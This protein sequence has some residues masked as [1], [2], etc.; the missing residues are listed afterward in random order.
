MFYTKISNLFKLNCNSKKSL[1]RGGFGQVIQCDDNIVLKKSHNDAPFD[2]ELNFL[3]RTQSISG[4]WVKMY[5]VVYIDQTKLG[6]EKIESTLDSTYDVSLAKPLIQAVF[7]FHKKTEHTHNDIKPNN[8]GVS[9][10]RKIVLLD[11]GSTAHVSENKDVQLDQTYFYQSTADFIDTDLHK[12]RIFNDL[13]ALG[14]VIY[15]L[16]VISNNP[17]LKGTGDQYLFYNKNMRNPLATFGIN[18]KTTPRDLQYI[19][20]LKAFSEQEMRSSSKLD[21]DQFLAPK[22]QQFNR[23]PLGKNIF[24]LLSQ[25]FDQEKFD[26]A[27]EED[28]KIDINKEFAMENKSSNSNIN[29]NVVREMKQFMNTVPK[30]YKWGANDH[31]LAISGGSSAGQG[32][33]INRKTLRKLCDI[34]DS[35]K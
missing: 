29:R 2:R 22:R 28:I 9:N 25:G 13:W 7:E 19:L 3:S 30:D 10:D 33:K 35:K 17:S 21:F 15:E 4:S 26:K 5:P 11:L 27:S 31:K 32:L 16:V 20:G 24:L 14:C 18:R 8:I 6:M 23:H 12:H 34:I 1:G